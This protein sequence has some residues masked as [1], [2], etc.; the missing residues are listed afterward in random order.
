MKIHH[1]QR[2]IR[3]SKLSITE[4]VLLSALVDLVDWQSWQ[5]ETKIKTIMYETGLNKATISRKLNTL[6]DRGFIKRVNQTDHRGY[7][8]SLYIINIKEVETQ[9]SSFF[10]QSQNATPYMQK[11]T[12]SSQG[13]TDQSQSATPYMQSE[14]ERL[15]RET[16][17]SQSAD[18]NILSSSNSSLPNKNSI[19]FNNSKDA[20]GA[21]KEVRRYPKGHFCEGAVIVDGDDWVPEKKTN[22]RQAWIEGG[23]TPPTH[24]EILKDYNK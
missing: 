5:G 3:R 18:T 6:E 19:S 16:K 4:R 1:L 10:P 12:P 20:Q 8:E 24:E 21:S 23:W 15:Q 14:T 2:A 22:N 7:K 11:E 17:R 13:A 9:L